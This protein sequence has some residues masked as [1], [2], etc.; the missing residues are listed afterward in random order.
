MYMKISKVGV[1][2][3][4]K[5][6]GVS[7]GDTI[8]LHCDA[9]VTSELAGNNINE[10]M[11]VLFDGIQELIGV[12][13]TLIIPTFTYSAT[14]GEVFDVAKTSSAV[15]QLTE[16][17]RKRPGVSRSLN[18]IF[19]VASSGALAEKFTN[20][21][22]DDCFGKRTSFDLLYKMNSW[23]FTLGCSWDRI[24]FIHFIEQA[25]QVDYRYF[26]SF[27]ATIVNKSETKNVIIRYLVRHLDKSTD[28]KLD[29]LKVRL[30]DENLLKSD[31]I[32]RVLL[33]GVRAKDFYKT[34]VKMLHEKPYVHIKEGN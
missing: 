5:K 15:G 27:P 4:F 12:N 2:E 8:F 20:S 10:K 11:S 16:F 3:I 28:V 31:E 6:C 17:F 14:K 32:G 29:K 23:I 7:N 26:K 25:E 18:P 9:M 24:T 22:V 1:G 30:S 21:S 19:S 33:N 34:A 13:G